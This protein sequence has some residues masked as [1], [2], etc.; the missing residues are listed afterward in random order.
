[1]PPQAARESVLLRDWI[2]A[3]ADRLEPLSGV[4]A[5]DDEL[6]GVVAEGE[7]LYDDLT[8]AGRSAVDNWR[9]CHV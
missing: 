8:A 5:L 7:A 6:P 4:A 9:R 2:R 3:N 1:M